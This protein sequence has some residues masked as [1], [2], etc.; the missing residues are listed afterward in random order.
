MGRPFVACGLMLATVAATSAG[1]AG[2]HY[3]KSRAN[4]A[5]YKDKS[6]NDRETYSAKCSKDIDA[7]SNKCANDRE[8]YTAKCS[9]DI[10]VAEANQRLASTSSR[11]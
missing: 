3:L 1:V 4:A 6:A 5:E 2:T 9:D 11:P 7:Y 8:T 10:R